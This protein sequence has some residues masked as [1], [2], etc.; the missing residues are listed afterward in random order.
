VEKKPVGLVTCA[1]VPGL[2]ADDQLLVKAL[3]DA[4]LQARPLVWD[5]PSVDWSEH[6]G[7]VIRSTWDYHE[8]YDDF[9]IWLENLERR[10]VPVF[11]TLSTLRWN[12]NKKYLK[13]CGGDG[14]SVVPTV[15][16]EPGQAVDLDTMMFSQNWEEAVLKP[17][18][19]AGAA[20][21][22]RVRRGDADGVGR[23][24]G[25]PRRD[26]AAVFGRDR[27]RGGAVLHLHRRHLLPRG[28]EDA[29]RRGFPRSG[30]VRRQSGPFLRG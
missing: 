8:K 10:C 5:D 1:S 7:L 27:Q 25:R 15:W 18:V 11:N 20:R 24:G 30:G 12:M 28:A 16:I 2:S 29:R 21:T 19:S 14:A 4:G 22:Y 3:N 13:E 26:A 17:V 9:A 6:S 23:R